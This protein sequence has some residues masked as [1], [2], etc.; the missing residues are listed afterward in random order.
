MHT[1]FYREWF[2]KVEQ[3]NVWCFIRTLD[4]RLQMYKDEGQIRDSEFRAKKYSCT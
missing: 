2:A 3:R 4:M 1:L